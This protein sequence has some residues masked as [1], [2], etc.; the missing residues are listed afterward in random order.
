MTR[1]ERVELMANALISEMA[2]A[3]FN[4]DGEESAKAIAEMNIRSTEEEFEKFCLERFQGNVAGKGLFGAIGTTYKFVQEIKNLESVMLQLLEWAA[5]LAGDRIQA[6]SIEDL[7]RYALADIK[8]S[9]AI[10][11]VAEDLLL[12]KGL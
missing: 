5:A 10:Q 6:A 3:W 8:Y 2:K 9:S 11:I 1:Q 7:K 12:E 4:G